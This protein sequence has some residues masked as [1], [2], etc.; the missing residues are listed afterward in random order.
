[1]VQGP[2]TFSQVFAGVK[3]AT[4]KKK[5]P[6]KRAMIEFTDGERT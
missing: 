6:A 4:K 2:A 5:A 1:M 3:K